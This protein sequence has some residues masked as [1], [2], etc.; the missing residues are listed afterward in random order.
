MCL[1]EEPVQ[2]PVMCDVVTA[3]SYLTIVPQDG[4]TSPLLSTN[5]NSSPL[6]EHSQC[7]SSNHEETSA[8]ERKRAIAEAMEWGSNHNNRSQASSTSI[9]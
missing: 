7:Q 4:D 3:L 9:C 5:S 1:Q 8:Q 2:R 6:S